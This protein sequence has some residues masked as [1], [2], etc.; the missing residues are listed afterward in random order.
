MPELPEL[1]VVCEVLRRRVVGRPIA[2][3]S[4]APKGAPLVVR[5]LTGQGL[6]AAATGRAFGDVRRRGKFILLALDGSDLTVAVNPKLTGRFQLCPPKTAKAGPVHVTYHFAE[7]AEELRFVDSKRM[8]Q[9]YLTRDLAAIPT[10]SEMGPEALEVSAEEFGRRLR[11]YRGEIK[12]VLTRADFLAGIGNA[13]ADEILW[14]AR[15]HP[16]RKRSSLS[17]EDIERLYRAMVDTLEQATGLVRDAMGEDIHLKPRAFF[18]VHMRGGEPCPRCGTAISA[19][20]ANQ[21]ITNFCRN[22]QPGGLI[23]GMAKSP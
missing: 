13:Y 21:R 15:L 10:F 11:R 3:V 16:Y 14:H 4:L 8:G 19:V 2:R 23:R 18:A 6:P 20:T 1:E 17:P 22:C 9:I 7:P 5:D 12:G